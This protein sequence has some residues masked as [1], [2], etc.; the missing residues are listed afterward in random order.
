[1]SIPL[2]HHYV[3]QCHIKNFFSPDGKIYLYDK[4]KKNFYSAISTKNIFSEKYSNSVY[5]NG[6]VDHVSLEED[7]K[8]FE[9]NFPKTVELIANTKYTKKITAECHNALVEIILYGLASTLRPPTAK[10]ELDG[11]Y[12]LLFDKVYEQMT[13]NLKRGLEQAVEFRKHVKY[14]NLL[15]YSDMAIRIYEKMGELAFTIWHIQ[16]GDRFLLS[17]STAFTVRHKI[18][19][20]FNPDIKEIAEVGI[21]LTDKLFVHAISKKLGPTNSYLAF[22]EK[23]NDS[24]VFNINFN[25]FHCSKMTVA[26][27]NEEFIKNLIDGLNKN[28]F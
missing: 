25:L 6:K 22:I 11:I 3:S 1:M 14:A 7:L 18:N 17:D 12:D 24:A 16:S 5:N 26:T 9:D 2:N 28:A 21:S 4:A 23:D 8:I 13:D 10:Q 19:S 27:S 20:Y 15:K